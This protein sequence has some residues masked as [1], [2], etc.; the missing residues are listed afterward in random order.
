MGSRPT[1]VVQL[2]TREKVNAFRSG[3]G[4]T[5][6]IVALGSDPKTLWTLA[7]IDAFYLSLTRAERWGARPLQ[8]HSVALLRTTESDQREGMPPYIVT[9]LV[10][11]DDEPNT[12]AF[13]IPL[14]VKAMLAVIDG[15]NAQ[16]PGVIRTIGFFEFELTFPGTSLTEVAGL[17][18]S[19]LKP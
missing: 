13:C 7:G 6:G 19:S 4:N 9:G 10:L 14:L 3:L 1:V 5:C 11:K 16:H 12:G 2:P 15:A 18:A 17:L 8:P